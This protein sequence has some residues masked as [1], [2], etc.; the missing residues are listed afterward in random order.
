MM[1]IVERFVEW[2]SAGETELLGETVPQRHFAHYKSHMTR[3]GF[4]LGPPLHE[5]TD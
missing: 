2:S 3:P 1:V 5:A 4:E